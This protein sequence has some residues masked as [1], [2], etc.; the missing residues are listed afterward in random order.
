MK[1]SNDGENIS[2]PLSITGIPDNAKSLVLIVDD[3]DAPFKTWVHWTVFNIGS[4]TTEISEK[5]LPEG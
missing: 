3:P 5:T 4:K 2:P 1:K